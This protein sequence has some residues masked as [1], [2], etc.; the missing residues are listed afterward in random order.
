[1]HDLPVV[2]RH[3]GPA[4][5]PDEAFAFQITTDDQAETDWGGV[6]RR[7]P[8]YPATLARV[9]RAVM[10]TT[11][12]G[13]ATRVS[14][15]AAVLPVMVPEP[16]RAAAAR[17]VTWRV[18][19]AP[20]S[21]SPVLQHTVRPDLRAAPVATTGRSAGRRRHEVTDRA[22]AVPVLVD[23]MPTFMA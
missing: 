1:V 19:D 4:F 9:T 8:P 15:L 11:R 3:G 10:A 14:P 7:R 13:A 6:A 12:A 5:R 16:D 17:T 21:R 18:T 2:R 20:A 23:R 22:V